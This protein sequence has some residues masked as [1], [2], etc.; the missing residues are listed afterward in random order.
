M[1]TNYTQL[2]NEIN[3]RTEVAV[4][5]TSEKL[6]E[7]LKEI[8]QTKYYDE[9]PNPRYDRTYMF[10]NSAVAKMITDS[11]ATIGIDDS[12]FDYEYSARYTSQSADSNLSKIGQSYD[13]HWTGEDQTFMASQG[14]HGSYYIHTEGKFWEEFLDYCNKNARNMLRDELRKQGVPIK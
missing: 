7:K 2:V 9:Y 5:I 11:T 14:Y 12:Y 1:I 6:C 3:K 10:L 4:K 13:G 8:I